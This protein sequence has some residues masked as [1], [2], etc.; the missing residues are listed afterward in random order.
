M[1]SS[2]VRLTWEQK[3]AIVHECRERGG[4][5]GIRKMNEV[6][7][8]AV[9][10]LKLHS[11]PSYRTMLRI[12]ADEERIFNKVG[13]KEKD[14]TCETNVS[15]EELETELA[16]W[17]SSMWRTGV[18]VSDALIKEKGRRIMEE[19]NERTTQDK[20]ISIAFSKGWIDKFK[21]RNGFQCME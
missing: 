19:L 7:A 16:N 10:K 5:G 12:L 17:V 9:N 20:K 4:G 15:S 1:H 13:S 6:S 21:K 11:P 8:W 14:R 3:L 18:F 2:R